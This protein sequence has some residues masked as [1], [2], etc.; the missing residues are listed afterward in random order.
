MQVQE[1][2]KRSLVKAITYR[3]VILVSDGIIIF[4]I[5]HEYSTTLWVIL[6][7]NIASTILY[8]THERAWNKVAW[9]KGVKVATK[10]KHHEK[11]KN[12]LPE[13]PDNAFFTEPYVPGGSSSENNS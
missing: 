7:S 3:L 2:K 6:I 12:N 10:S 8:F 13:L 1:R 11:H 5:T 9:G 4:A